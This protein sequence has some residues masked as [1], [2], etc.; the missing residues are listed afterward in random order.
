MRKLVLTAIDRRWRRNFIAFLFGVS[1]TF[2]LAPFFYFPLLLVAF[3]GLYGLLTHASSRKRAF[4]DGWWWGWGFYITSLYWFCEA[5][6]TEPEKFGWLIPF[7]LFGLTAVIALYPAI[8]A[9]LFYRFRASGVQ[10]VLRFAAIWTVV[11]YARG[12]L[13]TGFP[14]NLAGYSFGFSDMSL[15]VASLVGA[16]GLTFCAVLLG[17]LP[18]ALINATQRKQALIAVIAGYTVFVM[19]MAWGAWRLENAGAV[20]YVDGVKLR[21]IQA[22][23][24]QPHKWDPI[25]QRQGLDMH[26]NLNK[27]AG[28]NQITHFI[29]PETAVPTVVRSGAGFMGQIAYT[30]P[31]GKILLTGVMR[32]EPNGDTRKFYNSIM[33]INNQGQML[34]MYDKAKLVPFGEFLPFR[35]WLPKAITTPVGTA[36]LSSGPGSLTYQWQGLPP[37]SPLVCYEAIFPGFV[38]GS[39]IKP[40][41]MLN[42][43]NDAWFGMSIG[44]H[45]H[46]NMARMRAVEQG[47]PLVR[48]ANTGISAVID[49]YGRIIASLA[50]GERGVL[51]SQLP[52]AIPGNTIYSQV[53]NWQQYRL[54]N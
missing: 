28:A 9:L 30:L 1:T 10:G 27:V 34:G 25:M 35:E 8:A 41:W 46:F 51:D 5:L 52:K 32:D 29:W 17:V 38:T 48:S 6:L 33:V 26:V 39:D 19:S 53:T 15:Q 54:R 11:E 13:F 23:I 24:A 22:N 2:T 7:T 14:W 49:G 20:Q 4:A 40:E 50:L 12:H 44:P 16:Y 43:T 36:D 47:I 42:L 21:L 18:C 31:E 45:Q 3:G 37:V